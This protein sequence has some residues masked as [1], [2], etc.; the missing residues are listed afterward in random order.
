MG[1]TSV[2]FR[3]GVDAVVCL[4]VL[5]LSDGA[6]ALEFVAARRGRAAAV[7]DG[8]AASAGLMVPVTLWVSF[9]AVL[10]FALLRMNPACCDPGGSTPTGAANLSPLGEGLRA[11]HG[12]GVGALQRFLDV[13]TAAQA[14]VASVR[15][16]GADSGGSAGER[17]RGA[18]GCHG[19]N[20]A[21]PGAAERRRD[22]LVPR[23]DCCCLA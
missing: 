15:P 16:P 4:D 9:A 2:G 17:R 10:N 5:C 21:S 7:C 19:P 13:A 8:A 6:S 23:T 18:G 20:L 22:G 12:R 14:I 11:Q 1:A 3:P